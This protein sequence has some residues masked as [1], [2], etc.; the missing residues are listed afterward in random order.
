[1]SWRR[2]I[3]YLAVS[4]ELEEL[5][6]YRD[7]VLAGGDPKKFHWSSADKAGTATGSD[8]AKIGERVMAFARETKVPPIRG[9]IWDLARNRGMKP[10]YQVTKDDGSVVYVDDAGNE[11][12]TSGFTFVPSGRLK[13]EL[14]SEGR[15]VYVP[16]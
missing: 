3:V 10:I 7:Y 1:M 12:K 2:W 11:V 13:D 5:D 9:D 6:Q 15:R 4:L 14:T 16:E 8:P